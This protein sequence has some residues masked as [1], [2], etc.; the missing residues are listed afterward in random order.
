MVNLSSQLPHF[1]WCRLNPSTVFL[2]TLV[3]SSTL[4]QY[5]Y[6]SACVLSPVQ[7]VLRFSNLRLVFQES[8]VT[9]VVQ[10]TMLP[11]GEVRLTLSHIILLFHTSDS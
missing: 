2:L 9:P 10:V 4:R 11:F 8:V 3:E 7:A 6:L 5:F 1:H